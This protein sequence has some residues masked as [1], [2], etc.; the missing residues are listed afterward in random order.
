MALSYANILDRVEQLL[1][2]PTNAI[3]ST[4]ELGYWM[5]DGLKDFSQYL[6]VIVEAIYH[7]ESRTGTDTAGTANAL[8][9]TSKSQFVATD[10][11]TQKV[12]HNITD[13]TWAVVKNYTSSSVLALSRDI[14]D[15]GES[16]EIY[17]KHCANQKQIYL[18]DSPSHL[19]IDSVEY[20]IGTPRNFTQP[21]WNVVELDIDDSVIKDSDSTIDPPNDTR[22]LIR[23]AMPQVVSQLTDWDGES[24]GAAAEAASTID[25]DGMGTTETIEVG[26]MFNMEDH[27]TTYIITTEVT[28][29][30]GAGSI[31]FYPPLESA[32]LNN[33][34]I[35]FIKTTL[36]P[37]E[38]SLL[39]RL[40]AAKAAM[41]KSG[42]VPLRV[43]ERALPN[44]DA[45]GFTIDESN[46]GGPG[47]P[48]DY[49]NYARAERE[50]AG[51]YKDYREWG[52]R[53]MARVLTE[54]ERMVSPRA[55]EEFART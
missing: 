19:W 10:E 5:E 31:V 52:E 8:T 24:S 13:S 30:E 49:L 35:T 29:A 43:L 48:T 51:S 20:P 18:G 39:C 7:I 16:Y 36:K 22:V 2:D 6:P 45:G 11:S 3:F 14:M 23:F 32:V 34:D 28:M 1:Q 53:E 54:L 50:M 25:I 38:E 26:E 21:S 55:Y 12:I 27:L 17:N 9:D 42:I 41:S 47:T 44:L 4:T 33:D 40:V 15:S 46:K 37:N